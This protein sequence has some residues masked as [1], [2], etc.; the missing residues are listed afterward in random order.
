MEHK[1]VLFPYFDSS[2]KNTT[3]VVYMLLYVRRTAE[4][5]AKG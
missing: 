5:R 1:N 4:G 3:V 2:V